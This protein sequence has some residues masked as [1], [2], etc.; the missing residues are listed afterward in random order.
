MTKSKIFLVPST[1]IS[2]ASRSFSL[3]FTEATTLNTTCMH[4]EKQMKAFTI[5]TYLN[6][7]KGKLLEFTIL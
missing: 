7:T 4:K 1:L 6:H 2:T 3:N 5:I